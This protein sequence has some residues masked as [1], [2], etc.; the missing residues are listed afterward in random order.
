M[1]Y[2][3]AAESLVR[4]GTLRVPW[5]YWPEADST[6]P[7]SDLPPAFSVA[8]A[9]PLAAGAPRVQAARWVMVLG[10]AVAIGVFAALAADA[11]GAAAAALLTGL[12]PA[13]PAGRRGETHRR[14]EPPVLPPPPAP[15]RPSG[16]GPRP[17]GGRAR[18]RRARYRCLVA[19]PL[20]ERRPLPR[21]GS[22]RVT[23]TARGFGTGRRVLRRRRSV[24]AP[25]GR[26]GH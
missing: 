26:R 24:R 11:A 14:G 9:V 15:L 23:P 8:I 13:A 20:P 6:S 2:V 19:R 1:A 4:H 21:R 17:G 22:L 7:L 3:G 25:D 5:T 18:R 10:L 16:S 12:V